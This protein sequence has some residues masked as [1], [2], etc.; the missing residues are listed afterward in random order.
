LTSIDERALALAGI[1]QAVYLVTKIAKTGMHPQDCFDSSIS[2]L[3]VFDAE[4]TAD[5]YSGVE[6]LMVGLRI[7][8]EVLDRTGMNDI[9]RDNFDVFRY[10]LNLL[11]LE[12]KLSKQPAMMD[13]IGQ[14]LVEIHRALETSS[15]L[16]GHVLSDIAAL[17]EETVSTLALRIQVRGEMRFLQN[18]VNVHKVRALLLSGI[19]SSVLWHQLGGRRWHLLFM[20]SHLKS[21][22]RR[23][24]DLINI[25]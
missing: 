25:H 8:S 9:S 6:N 1:F 21:A 22:T 7:S 10:G 20:R 13:Y 17:Y 19:R 15:S 16:D 18:D 14:R 11:Q 23:Q 24:M 2:S 5:I 3:F 12:R 4:S